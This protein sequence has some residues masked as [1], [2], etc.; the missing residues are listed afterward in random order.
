MS[1]YYYQLFTKLNHKIIDTEFTKLYNSKKYLD[2][3]NNHFINSQNILIFI[4]YNQ[5]PIEFLPLPNRKYYYCFPLITFYGEKIYNANKIVLDKNLVSDKIV[6]RERIFDIYIKSNENYLD[7]NIM[8]KIQSS[9]KDKKIDKDEIFTL[10]IPT[11]FIKLLP[12]NYFINKILLIYIDNKLIICDNFKKNSELI[13]LNLFYEKINKNTYKSSRNLKINIKNIKY[14]SIYQ[15]FNHQDLLN[16]FPIVTLMEDAL[17]Y[18]ERNIQE[19][20]PSKNTGGVPRFYTLY[21]K[22]EIQEPIYMPD[23]NNYYCMQYKLKESVNLLDLTTNIY[24][25][26]DEVD[27]KYTYVDYREGRTE[28]KL[29]DNIFRCIGDSKFL[30][31]IN[32]CDID[33]LTKFEGRTFPNYNKRKAL[34]MIIWKN[35]YYSDRNIKILSFLDNLNFNGYFNNFSYIWYAD[36]TIKL[37]GNEVVFINSKI[38]EKYVKKNKD[39]VIGLCKNIYTDQ[40]KNL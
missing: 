22:Y 38:A 17:L 3:F 29:T 36:D 15:K 26:F 14:L 23:P 1:F 6:H 35:M 19:Y 12:E 30:E 32:E 39:K 10:N 40:Y 16:V 11:E 18:N 31:K 33:I 9:L 28:N 5:I 2:F 37:L 27:K 21:P 25:L 8:K 7:Q 13:I 24:Y 20:I 34:S 4:T